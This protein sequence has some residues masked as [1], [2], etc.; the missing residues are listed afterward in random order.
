MQSV[1]Q[2]DMVARVAGDEFVVI[3]QGLDTNPGRALKTLQFEFIGLAE[4]TGVTIAP[5]AWAWLR[6][7]I[8][9]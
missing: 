1:R 8:W 3:M 7:W 2:D 6:T 5:G 9:K 4:E